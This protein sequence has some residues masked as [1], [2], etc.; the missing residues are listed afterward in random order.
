MSIE[1]LIIDDNPDIRF[2]LNELIKDEGYVTRLAANY[3][4]ALTEIDKKS[5]QNEEN[6]SCRYFYYCY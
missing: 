1:I 2:L 3:G 6:L 4:Q 5:I